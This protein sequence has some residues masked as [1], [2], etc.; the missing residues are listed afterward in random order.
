VNL[1]I[2]GISIPF[3]VQTDDSLNSYDLR[4]AHNLALVLHDGWRNLSIAT[5]GIQACDAAGLTG[6]CNPSNREPQ[7]VADLVR[8]ALHARAAFLETSPAFS[9]PAYSGAATTYLL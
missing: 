9:S 5:R 7:T 1:W 8:M 2:A 6:P 3:H 4:Q